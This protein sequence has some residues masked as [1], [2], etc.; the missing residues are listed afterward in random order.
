MKINK[1]WTTEEMRFF[2]FGYAYRS[3]QD[4]YPEATPEELSIYAN[5]IMLGGINKFIKSK[6]ATIS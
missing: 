6:E 3:A 5:D 1:D 2:L 4:I